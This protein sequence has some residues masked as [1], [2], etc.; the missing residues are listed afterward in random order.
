MKFLC[1]ILAFIY[2]TFIIEITSVRIYRVN[3]NYPDLLNACSPDQI[4]EIAIKGNIETIG[5]F[6]LDKLATTEREEALILIIKNAKDS[7]IRNNAM[8]N[9]SSSDPEVWKDLFIY[10]VN[11]DSDCRL[12]WQAIGHLKYHSVPF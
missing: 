4:K 12:V 6:A 7:E 5:E 10:I 1:L 8:Y 2:S 3:A 11:N 9:L